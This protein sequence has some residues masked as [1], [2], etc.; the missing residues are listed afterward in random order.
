LTPLGD[1]NVKLTPLQC[2]GCGA[3]LTPPEGAKEVR[4]A[5][6]NQTTR[7]RRGRVREPRSRPVF[8]VPLVFV[9]LSVIGSVAAAV[10]FFRAGAVQT[11]VPVANLAAKE[12]PPA[13]AAPIAAPPA[14]DP[15][16]PLRPDPTPTPVIPPEPPLPVEHGPVV[17]VWRGRVRS[18]LGAGGMATGSA[19][20]L[21]VR[22]TSDG[23][24]AAQDLV[25]FQCGGRVL[26][27]SS[28]PLEGMSNNSFGLGEDPLS[29]EA[30]A[31][32]YVI[33]AD[34]IGTRSGPKAQLTANS[35]AGVAEAFRDSAPSFHV[36]A[37]LERS[38]QPRKGQPLFAETLPAFEAVV[39]R[40]ARVTTKT[41]AVPFGVSTCDLRISPAYREG[42]T[43]RVALVC[44]G[45]TVYGSGTGGFNH[46]AVVDGA[47]VTL[48]DANPTPS[49][50]DP[51]LT[52]DLTART[53][54]LA[55]TTATGA[56]YSVAF[57]LL[58]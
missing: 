47:P 39:R 19:C 40:K 16:E 24:H 8:L 5:F 11:S 14:V 30:H 56:S 28:L 17:L 45:A 55:D 35:Q 38:S 26:Y 12:E 27:D 52:V 34:D 48:V 50:G 15:L 42:D 20:T 46:C 29:G 10:V 43:C 25:S 6:C 36:Y 33:R 2:P 41:G 1:A 7:L 21:T 18:S 37:S 22:A 58:E 54:T 51:Q 3:P 53:A 32:Q 49:G 9:G 4:C 44:G 31:Y 57:T 23:T 13:V